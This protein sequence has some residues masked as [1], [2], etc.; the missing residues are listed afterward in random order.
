MFHGFSLMFLVTHSFGMIRAAQIT[1]DGAA[2]SWQREGARTRQVH[3][4]HG[5]W[6]L[7]DFEPA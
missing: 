5:S 4:F 2:W 3:A 1:G 6:R 7:G